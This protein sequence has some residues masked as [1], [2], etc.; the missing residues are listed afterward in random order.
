MDALVIVD[1]Q[2]DF[3]PGG[4]LAV[5]GAEK[6]VPIINQLIDQFNLVVASKDWHPKDHMSFKNISIQGK[7]PA[8]CVQGSF[9]AMFPPSLKEE[10]IKKVFTKGSYIDEDSY[11]AFYIGTKNHPSGLHEFL[12][13]EKVEKVFLAGLALDVCVYKTALDALSY[14]YQVFIIIDATEAIDKK[15]K[16]KYLRSLEKEGAVLI[17]CNDLF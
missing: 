17:S 2:N 8:H 1:L 14:G 16:K 6:I 7:W 15:N 13:E 4:T 11:S 5:F 3:L 12:Q 10:K 9:G